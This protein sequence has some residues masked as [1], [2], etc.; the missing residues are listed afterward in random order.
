MGWVGFIQ[1]LVE[2]KTNLLKIFE[3]GSGTGRILL[4]GEMNMEV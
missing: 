1:K 3:L 2:N 4:N